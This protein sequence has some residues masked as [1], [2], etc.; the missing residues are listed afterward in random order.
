[1][2]FMWYTCNVNVNICMDVICYN[3][4]LGFHTF[5]NVFCF[6]FFSS[7]NKGRLKLDIFVHMLLGML[8][9]VRLSPGIVSLLGINVQALRRWDLPHP[10]PWEFAWMFSLVAAVVGWRS[11]PQNSTFL[12]KQYILG[13]IVFGV[14]PVFF[15]FIELSDDMYAYIINRKYTFV[16]FGMPAIVLWILFLAICAQLHGLALYFSVVLL[17]AWRPRGD[18]LKLR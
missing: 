12:L 8:M 13:T 11:I 14:L 3:K 18:K 5:T 1:M 16:M 15:G 6:C 7:Q 10:R 17:K 4:N 2:Y 9:L